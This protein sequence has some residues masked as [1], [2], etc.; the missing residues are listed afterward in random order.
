[1]LKRKRQQQLQ[2]RLP[3]TL[4][5]LSRT[6]ASVPRYRDCPSFCADQGQQ[7]GEEN[8]GTTEE[9]W[10]V[11]DGYRGGKNDGGNIRNSQR[12]LC[13]RQVLQ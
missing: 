2:K 4:C 7:G 10:H 8:C 13:C 9:T 12:C 5:V 3:T 1:M 6:P 11:L